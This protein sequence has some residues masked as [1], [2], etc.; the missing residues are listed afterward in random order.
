[1]G[2]QPFHHATVAGGRRAVVLTVPFNVVSCHTH[3]V[4]QVRA[5]IKQLAESS[6][7][8]VARSQTWGLGTFCSRTLSQYQCGQTP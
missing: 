2:T 7:S 8:P 5:Q 4:M 1:M 3:E 6:A